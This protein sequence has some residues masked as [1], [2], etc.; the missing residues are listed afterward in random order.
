MDI[1]EQIL[2]ITFKMGLSSA[3]AQ[4]HQ[5]QHRIGITRIVVAYPATLA[6]NSLTVRLNH[7]A[8][9]SVMESMAWILLFLPRRQQVCTSV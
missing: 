9:S 7:G 5:T 2:Q 1:M 3:S 6:T 8:F 4:I